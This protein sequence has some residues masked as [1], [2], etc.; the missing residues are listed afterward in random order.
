MLPTVPGMYYME[1]YNDCIPFS[2]TFLFSLFPHF[3]FQGGLSLS[4]FLS[5][6]AVSVY[7]EETVP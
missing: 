7:R 5:P 3:Y 6:L 2:T 4:S 1:A